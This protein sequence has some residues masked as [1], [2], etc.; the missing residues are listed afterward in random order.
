VEATEKAPRRVAVEPT[1]TVRRRAA[2]K[3]EEEMVTAPR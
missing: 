1:E 2:E 3:E